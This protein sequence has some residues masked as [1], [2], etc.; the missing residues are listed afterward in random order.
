MGG[1]HDKNYCIQKNQCADSRNLMTSLLFREWAIAIILSLEDETK[2][3]S[4]LCLSLSGGD[5]KNVHHRA[6]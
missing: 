5:S 6:L 3:Y 4:A 1:N 2:R